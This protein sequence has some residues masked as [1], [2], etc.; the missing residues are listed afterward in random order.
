MSKIFWQV[1]TAVNTD[2]RQLQTKTNKTRQS[3]KHN[4]K[5]V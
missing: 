2:Q 1:N 3:K 5:H 4:K